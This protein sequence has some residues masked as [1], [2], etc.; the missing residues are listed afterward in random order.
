MTVPG[1]GGNKKKGRSGIEQIGVHL[2]YYKPDEHQTLNPEQKKEL[3]LW[4]INDPSQSDAQ[5][6]RKFIKVNIASIKGNIAAAAK[7]APEDE[8]KKKSDENATHEEEKAYIMSLLGH[9]G[10]KIKGA[11]IG[12]SKREGT[13]RVSLNDILKKPKNQ[14]YQQIR[15]APS[16]FAFQNVDKCNDQDQQ[17]MDASSIF[18]FQSV[19]QSNDKVNNYLYTRFI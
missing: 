4:R 8:N 11:T 13:T 16:I 2:R 5:K 12:S 15:D 1:T 17:I 18:A 10:D 6:E 14:R 19:N 3:A 9:S 7:T